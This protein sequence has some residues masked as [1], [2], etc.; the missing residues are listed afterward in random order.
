MSHMNF[1]KE[2]TSIMSTLNWA[3]ADEDYTPSKQQ[4]LDTESSC[5]TSHHHFG[6]MQ[7]VPSSEPP[8]G[9]FKSEGQRS[10]LNKRRVANDVL[11]QNR[12][13]LFAGEFDGYNGFAPRIVTP[14]MTVQAHRGHPV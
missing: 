13:E 5:V 2:Y 14:L 3:T 9:D 12:Q 7:V 11:M 4:L 1:P 8:T 10:R 6:G